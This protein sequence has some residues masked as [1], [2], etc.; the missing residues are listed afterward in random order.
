[1]DCTVQ[2]Y[3]AV[4]IGDPEEM[5]EIG[6]EVVA[7]STYCMHLA[8]A[9]PE[10]FLPTK[11]FPDGDECDALDSGIGGALLE[12]D[13]ELEFYEAKVLAIEEILK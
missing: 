5:E 1:M 12:V 10:L 2:R 7:L 3:F 8:V 9:Q 11:Q 4:V 6:E 13:F